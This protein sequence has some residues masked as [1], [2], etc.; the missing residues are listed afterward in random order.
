MYAAGWDTSQ[1]K[2]CGSAYPLDT[3]IGER[4]RERERERGQ[5]EEGYRLETGKMV[6]GDRESERDGR[7]A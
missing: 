4:E 5:R 2:A 1:L 3:Q 6:K 7:G